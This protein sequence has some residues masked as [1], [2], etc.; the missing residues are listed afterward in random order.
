MT[1]WEQVKEG[2]KRIK[3]PWDSLKIGEHFVVLDPR[4][5]SNARQSV[6]QANKRGEKDGIEFE[7]AKF[8]GDLI[9]RRVS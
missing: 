3:W 4:N 9:V 8:E 2:A 5:R 6:F 7:C 1:N